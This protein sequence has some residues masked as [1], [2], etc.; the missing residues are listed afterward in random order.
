KHT[1]VT[2]PVL[3]HYSPFRETKV[4]TDSSDG[5]VSGILSQREGEEEWHPVAYYS[6]TM[7]PPEGNY[8]IQDKELLA[9]VKSFAEWRS[10]LVG[11]QVDL[12]VK[13]Y[14]DHEA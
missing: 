1:M 13:V 14:T 3:W 10:E 5:V 12:P 2:A 9:I 7:S 8:S 4:E 11:L 6:H